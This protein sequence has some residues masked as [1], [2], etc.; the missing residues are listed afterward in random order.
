MKQRRGSHQGHGQGERDERQNAGIE[1]KN[2]HAHRRTAVAWP[3]LRTPFQYD[4]RENDSTGNNQPVFQDL[5]PMAQ[6]GN[7]G[8]F[9]T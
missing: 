3:F 4:Q 8:P 2:S 5:M 7:D 1:Q 9:S 6:Y